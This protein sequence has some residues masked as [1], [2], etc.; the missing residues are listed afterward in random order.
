MRVLILSWEYPPLIEGGLARHV[1]KLAENLVAHGVDVHV[2][3]RGANG[4]IFC[5]VTRSLVVPCSSVQLRLASDRRER[6]PDIHPLTEAEVD[7]LAAIALNRWGK[8]GYGQVARAWILFG[9]WVGTRPG[10]TFAVRW[11][12]LNLRDSLVTVQRIKGKREHQDLPVAS[13]V[14]DAIQQMPRLSDL[15][16]PT[17]SGRRMEKGSLRYYFDPVRSAF[18]EKVTPERWEQLCE[19]QPDLHPYVL[20]HFCASMIVERGGNEYD[21]SAMLGN[22]PEVAREVYIHKYED[23]QRDRLRGLLERPT[24]IDLEVERRKKGA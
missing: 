6:P 8:D 19:G 17:V 9:A 24:V 2:I 1:R 22:T 15:V 10:E 13:V 18:R 11:Q 16:F 21:V 20:R 5:F 4:G 12:D 7:Q 14:I 23:R 3:A